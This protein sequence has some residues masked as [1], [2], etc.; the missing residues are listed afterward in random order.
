M[1]SEITEESSSTNCLQCERYKKLGDVCVIEHGKKFLWEYCKD[2]EA[3]VVLPDYKELMSSVRKD[4]AAERQKAREKRRREKARRKKELGIA[5]ESRPPTIEKRN[6][7]RVNS[8][9][10]VTEEKR[11]NPMGTSPF[12]GQAKVKHQNEKAAKPS[13]VKVNSVKGSRAK[14]SKKATKP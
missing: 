11:P 1:E 2:F 6:P 8:S 3:E 7:N 13:R 4:L 5:K 14:S 9:E 12:G 10:P